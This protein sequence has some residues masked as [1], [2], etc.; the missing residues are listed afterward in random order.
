MCVYK[1]TEHFPL[2]S[3]GLNNSQT[4]RL[5][6]ER[7]RFF[8]YVTHL[9]SVEISLSIVLGLLFS[10]RFAWASNFL[11]CNIPFPCYQFKYSMNETTSSCVFI[12]Y[13]FASRVQYLSHSLKFNLGQI[14]AIWVLRA[15]DHVKSDSLLWYAH[16]VHHFIPV[17]KNGKDPNI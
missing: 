10:A 14:I 1:H 9:N 4:E 13:C 15:S 16:L 17:Q 7:W 3:V 2:C 6:F 11:V 8:D 12:F 5:V